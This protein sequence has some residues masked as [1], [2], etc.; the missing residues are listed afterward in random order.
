MHVLVIDIGWSSVKVFATAQKQFFTIPSGG[1]LTPQ[2]L[3]PQILER[4]AG[5]K[6]AVVSIGYPGRVQHGRPGKTPN[7]DVGG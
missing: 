2:R 3:I 1:N 6:Y 5:W 7:L 4:T